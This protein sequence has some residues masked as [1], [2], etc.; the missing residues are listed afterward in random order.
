MLD[1]VLKRKIV[2]KKKLIIIFTLFQELLGLNHQLD[3]TNMNSV[4]LK[5]MLILQL[6]HKLGTKSKETSQNNYQMKKKEF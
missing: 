6:S 2:M 3:P 5:L 4:E 1:Q